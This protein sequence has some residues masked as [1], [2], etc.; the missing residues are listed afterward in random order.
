MQHGFS[1][2]E[3]CELDPILRRSFIYIIQEQKGGT[4]NWK[5]GKIS[6]E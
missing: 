2:T 1:L 3:A 6:H 4:V 5:T